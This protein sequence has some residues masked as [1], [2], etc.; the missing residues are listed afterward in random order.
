MKWTLFVLFVVE[1]ALPDNVNAADTAY[2]WADEQGQIHYGDRLPASISS[3]IINLQR[4]SSKA[5]RHTG[6]RPGE[7]KQLDNL[8]QRQ[9]QQQRRAQAAANQADRQRANQR[10]QCAENREM[11]KNSR[12]RDTFK[13]HSRYLRNNCW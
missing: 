10:A 2:Q 11:L 3:R 9:R 4:S 5:A 6:L 13:K 7:R 12:G 1:L 8:E